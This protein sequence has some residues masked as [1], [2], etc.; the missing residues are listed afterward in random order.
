MHLH[1]IRWIKA[2]SLVC[3]QAH[4]QNKPILSS[5]RGNRCHQRVAPTYAFRQRWYHP[6][7]L[8][9]RCVTSLYSKQRNQALI[10]AVTRYISIR[11]SVYQ[12][13]FKDVRH[14]NVYSVNILITKQKNTK[15]T[16]KRK[17]V[18]L[19]AATLVE[20]SKAYSTRGTLS[21]SHHLWM[22]TYYIDWPPRLNSQEVTKF[23][24]WC[25]KPQRLTMRHLVVENRNVTY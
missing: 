24:Q 16:E 12:A 9:A 14:A 4:N 7:A 3:R 5:T 23:V 19:L 17:I 6:G 20:K 13:S 22:L 25:H 21:H 18:T 8:A 11:I 2:L 10:W 1:V 15:W